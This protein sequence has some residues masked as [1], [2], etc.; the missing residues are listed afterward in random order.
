MNNKLIRETIQVIP[1][2]FEA[3]QAVLG[4][5]MAENENMEIVEAWLEPSSFHTAAHQYVFQAMTELGG[6]S[7]T[8]V[9]VGDKLKR[10]DRLNEVGGYAYLADLEI[11]EYGGRIEELA[12]IIKD[13]STAREL[14]AVAADIVRDGR[15][16]RRDVHE[17]ITEASA[18]IEAIEVTVEENTEHVKDILPRSFQ[19]LEKISESP[20]EIPGIKTGF[21]DLDKTTTGFYPGDMIII[22]GR[23]SMGKTSLSLNIASYIATT[24][25]VLFF[26]LESN[27]ERLVERLLSSIAMV[28]NKKLKRGNL[29]GEEWDRL[30]NATQRLTDMNIYI[31]D[32]AGISISEIINTAKRYHRKLKGGLKAV[33]IDHIGLVDTKQGQYREMEVAFIS[34]KLKALAKNLDIVTVPLSQL[35]RGVENGSDKRPKLSDLRESGSLEQNADIVM[36]VYRDEY[37][38]EDSA[39]K[40]IA[41]I[42]I[43]KNRDGETGLVRL[44]F[45]GKYTK[46]CNLSQ[47]SP[48]PSESGKKTNYDAMHEWQNQT[49]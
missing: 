5:I 30:A 6:S 17:L 1:H 25:N 44:G 20:D 29:E 45:V 22:A 11:E 8:S 13:H 43:A 12:K 21:I 49:Y 19:R 46:F 3:E 39:D 41:E 23:P 32:K 14:I 36:M 2:D 47:Q 7:I 37:Y 28:N 31:N 48:P 18:R 16:I 26:S 15:D 42:N 33:F 10:E 27:K 4:S 35:N 24:D 40:G 9:T 38:N 34:K